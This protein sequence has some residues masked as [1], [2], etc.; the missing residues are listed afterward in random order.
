MGVNV[1]II[2]K[3][4]IHGLIIHEWLMSKVSSGF[5]SLFNGPPSC[6]QSAQ[7]D[8]MAM[9]A[10]HCIYTLYIYKCHALNIYKDQTLYI[11]INAIHCI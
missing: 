2:T 7:D 8:P 4:L 11:Y 3:E 6:L 10:L 1:E 9:F 5:Y